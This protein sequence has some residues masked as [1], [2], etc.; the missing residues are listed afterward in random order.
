MLFCAMMSPVWADS[1][2]AT[3]TSPSS[4]AEAAANA[5]RAITGNDNANQAEKPKGELRIE[6][7]EHV[8]SLI[9]SLFDEKAPHQPGPLKADAVQSLPVGKYRLREIHLKGGFNCNVCRYGYG[10][11]QDANGF[12]IQTDQPY[13]IKIGLLHQHIEATRQGCTFQLAYQLLDSAGRQYQTLS[14][15]KP[16][17]FT[18]LCNGREVGSGAFEYG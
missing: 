6:G 17:R 3:S 10:T 11:T 4:N 1:D 8:E 2:P 15:D 16:P 9:L 18:L 7:G 13:T 12:T 5:V 14:R